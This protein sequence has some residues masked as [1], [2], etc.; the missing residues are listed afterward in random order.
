M[1]TLQ[2]IRRL[3]QF[4]QIG[5]LFFDASR[6]GFWRSFGAAL[7]CLPVWALLE[8][9]HVARMDD[10]LGH[11]IA[12]Q[13]I[14]YVVG[15]LAY[16]LVALLVTDMFGAWS[17]YYRYMVAYNW[18]QPV[19]QL[20]WLPVELFEFLPGGDT[21]PVPGLLALVIMAVQGVYGWFLARFGLC[22]SA[23]TALAL[24]VLDVALGLLIDRIA[25][26]L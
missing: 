26:Q 16:P 25:T 2:G 23:S 8:Y 10:G 1:L 14:A 5:F 15:W 11:F 19:M 12:M 21:S 9:V 13:S 22:V 20:M 17:N 24:T 18:F 3:S 6:K 4:D 7:V